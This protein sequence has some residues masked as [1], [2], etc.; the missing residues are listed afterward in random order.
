VRNLRDR[1]DPAAN[2]GVPAHI[3][4][5]FP[6]LEPATITLDT[7]AS[8]RR[9][10]SGFR[11]FHFHLGSIAQF[12]DTLYL[13]PDPAAPFV[14]LTE[15]VVAEF[16]DYP[17][18]GGQ[19]S[20]VI[21]HLTV[22]HGTTA[23]LAAARQELLAALDSHGDLRSTCTALDLIENSSGRWSQAHRIPLGER[24]PPADT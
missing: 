12:V 6:F 2:Q 5:L 21:P 14:A 15:A 1:L 10:L 7:I 20:I 4:V 3:T 13:A 8:V 9:A 11:P 22:A 18:Y 24:D 19:F 16:P 23:D 17:P